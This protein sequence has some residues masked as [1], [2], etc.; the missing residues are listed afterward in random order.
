MPEV[1][2][3][4]TTIGYS[5]TQGGSYTLIAEVESLTIPGVEIEKIPNTHMLSVNKVRTFQAGLQEI[6]PAEV[7]IHFDKTL[8]A[9]L[10]GTLRGA[11]YWYKVTFND[12]AATASTLVFPGFLSQI[13]PETPLDAIAVVN[14][15]ITPTGDVTFT[16][17]T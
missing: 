12:L 15:E 11:D 2:G 3:Y 13:G 5:T 6:T 14:L 4:G 1:L 7:V 8:L 10:Y 16:A 9:T 17:G